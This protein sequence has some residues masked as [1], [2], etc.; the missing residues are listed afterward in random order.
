MSSTIFYININRLR[1]LGVSKNSPTP[2]L[3]TDIFFYHSLPK[4]LN[5]PIFPSKKQIR[6]NIILREGLSYFAFRPLCPACRIGPADSTG[7][8]YRAYFFG[9][10]EKEIKSNDSAFSASLMYNDS[11]QNLIKKA[12]PAN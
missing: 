11:N 12:A 6:S 8:A 4:S 9:V 2:Q 3:F 5:T 7:V 10:S 1:A